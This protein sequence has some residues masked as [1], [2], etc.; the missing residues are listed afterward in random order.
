MSLLV[1]VH[2]IQ[3]KQG[4][5]GT[6]FLNDSSITYIQENVDGTALVYLYS[7]ITNDH[8]LKI[9]AASLVDLKAHMGVYTPA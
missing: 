8:W 4:P 1:S 7:H 3:N 9:D 2:V 6:V 5:S